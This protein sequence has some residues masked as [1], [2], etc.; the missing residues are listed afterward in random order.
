MNS[1]LIK[2]EAIANGY[3]EGIALDAAGYVSEGSGE[4]IFLVR[5]GTIHTPP[6]SASVLPG[7]TRDTVLA[8]ARDQDIPLVETTIPREM[9]YIADE[10]F[11]SGTAAEI[12]PIRSI[13]RISI[14]KGRRGPVAE[15]L[16]K[17][18]FG[19]IN[20]TRPDRHGWLSPVHVP[21]PAVVK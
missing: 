17:E 7:I 16:Q 2:M 18:F 9:L 20:G 12:T 1:Q 3:S 4:N 5:D 11:F 8:L 19:V 15:K 14:G 13:D 21:Q 6:L 10:V